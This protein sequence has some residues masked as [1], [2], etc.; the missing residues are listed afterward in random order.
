MTV[1]VDTSA[2]WEAIQVRFTSAGVPLAVRYQDRVWAVAADP[3]HWFTRADWWNQVRSAAK[4]SGDLVSVEYWRV[5]VRL[6]AAASLR[7]FTLRREP[8][9]EQWLLDD[10]SDV[11]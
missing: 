10:V 4:G 8:M 9:T 1:A 7:T 5:Q 11:L 2:A 3:V 6:T